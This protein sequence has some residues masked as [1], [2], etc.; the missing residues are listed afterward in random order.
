MQLEFHEKRTFGKTHQVR[1]ID[2]RELIVGVVAR[3]MLIVNSES[4][5]ANAHFN[6]T[7][8]DVS[9]VSTTSDSTPRLYM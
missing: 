9:P 8:R 4:T 2:I 1:L 6:A 5:L 7:V 3:Q